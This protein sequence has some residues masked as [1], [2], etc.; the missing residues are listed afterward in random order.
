[1]K[2]ELQ[3]SSVSEPE[4]SQDEDEEIEFGKD[5]MTNFMKSNQNKTKK[6]KNPPFRSAS[7]F[8]EVERA[9][10]RINEAVFFLPPGRT[11]SNSD[12]ALLYDGVY[13]RP[14]G[15]PAKGGQHNNRREQRQA[16]RDKQRRAILLSWNRAAPKSQQIPTRAEREE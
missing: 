15:R 14:P 16:G 3:E 11:K 13:P 2:K 6:K 12:A 10:G 4:V 1:M 9:S 5:S 7:I 8:A